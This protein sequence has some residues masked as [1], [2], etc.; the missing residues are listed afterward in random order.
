MNFAQ[1]SILVICELDM[2]KFDV[3]FTTVQEFLSYSNVVH[4][5]MLG[6]IKKLNIPRNSSDFPKNDILETTFPFRNEKSV[7]DLKFLPTRKNNLEVICFLLFLVNSRTKG[8]NYPIRKRCQLLPK[9]TLQISPEAPTDP[10][11]EQI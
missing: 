8:P 6:S 3:D 5:R 9:N 10:P 4:N 1:H 7:Y 11:C 2:N